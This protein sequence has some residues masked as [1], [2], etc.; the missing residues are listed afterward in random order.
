MKKES[1]GRGGGKEREK[2][3]QEVAGKVC[4][5]RMKPRTEIAPVTPCACVILILSFAAS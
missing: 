2:Q 5:C 3:R 4:P 1:G